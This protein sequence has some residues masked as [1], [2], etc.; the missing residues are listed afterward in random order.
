MKEKRRRKL[1]KLVKKIKLPPNV[2][3][4]SAT[5]IVPHGWSGEIKLLRI[6]SQSHPARSSVSSPLFCAVLDQFV[7]QNLAEIDEI[8]YAEELDKIMLPAAEMA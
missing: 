4:L 1:E 5:F 3:I 2:S 8:V 6:V 7:R